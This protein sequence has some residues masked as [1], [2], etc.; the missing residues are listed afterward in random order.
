MRPDEAARDALTHL[1]RVIAEAPVKDGPALAAAL[2]SLGA[3]RD[4][5]VA[6]HRHR[7]TELTRTLLDHVNAAISSVLA[8]QFP[9]GEVPWD[10]LNKAHGWLRGVSDSGGLER[11]SGPD[12]R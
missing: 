7:A 11:L 6:S 10:E 4:G 9:I 1:E 2:R 12:S 3:C 5:I 8:A